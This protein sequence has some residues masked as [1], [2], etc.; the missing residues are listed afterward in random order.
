MTSLYRTVSKVQKKKY[1][2]TEHSKQLGSTLNV[3]S[4]YSSV[5][6]KV[7]KQIIKV[8]EMRDWINNMVF[9]TLSFWLGFYRVSPCFPLLP[10]PQT[11]SSF[12]GGVSPSA[13]SSSPGV[14]AFMYSM[15]VTNSLLCGAL[16]EVLENG[17]ALV[18]GS[19]M[20]LQEPEGKR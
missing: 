20:Y 6:Y 19:L 13:P 15:W 2:R 7:R 8:G 11:T 17:F 9:T 3:L 12:L 5:D 10:P 1:S 16:A 14:L 4:W 18:A